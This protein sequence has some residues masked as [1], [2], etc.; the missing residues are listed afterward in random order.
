[1]TR[2]VGIDPGCEYIGVAGFPNAGAV[3]ATTIR[4]RTS[5]RGRRCSDIFHQIRPFVA[6]ADLVVL[7]GYAWSKAASNRKALSRM[8]EARGPILHAIYEADAAMMEIA[9]TSLKKFA[10]GKGNASK[11]DMIEAAADD[12]MH[13]LN[14]HEADAYWL[15]EMAHA[16]YDGDGR[17]DPNLSALKWPRL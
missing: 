4:I 10:T 8:A 6:G 15:R 13:G 1:M 12:W 2:I 5:D 11:D 17:D 14:E 9:P 16:W 3:S 7:E